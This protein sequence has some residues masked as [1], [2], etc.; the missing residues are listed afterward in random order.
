MTVGSA[1]AAWHFFTRLGE[2]QILLPAMLGAL[3]WLLYAGRARATAAWW[4]V[5]TC[6]AAIITTATKIAFHGFELG[7]APL[8]YAGVSGHAMFAAAIWPVIV[9]LAVSPA[10]RYLRAAVIAAGFLLA[11]AIAASRLVVHAHS[12]IEAAIGFVLGAAVSAAVLLRAPP[13]ALARP[14][15]IV[16]PLL[17]WFALVP[18]KA[19]PSPTHGWVMRL[20]MAVADRPRPYTRWQMHRDW[21]RQHAPKPQPSTAALAPPHRLR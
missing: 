2:A 6:I 4:A 11:F 8:D 15:H 16:A 17:V 19:P 3:A 5:G 9:A 18:L 13:P 10:R 20:S 7:Y 21:A 1:P 14:W 12:P